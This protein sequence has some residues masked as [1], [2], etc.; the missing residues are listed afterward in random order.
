VAAAAAAAAFF[1]RSAQETVWQKKEAQPASHCCG[2]CLLAPAGACLPAC[3]ARPAARAAG[4][5][6]WAM[7]DGGWLLLGHWD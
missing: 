1:L 7:V 4:A 2:R 3:H 6:C 5:R